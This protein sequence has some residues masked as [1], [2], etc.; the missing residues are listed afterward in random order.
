MSG[1]KRR[2]LTRRFDRGEI[3]PLLIPLIL[4]T[5]LLFGAAYFGYWA[6]MQRQD[7]KNNSDQKVAAAVSDAKKAEDIIKDQKFAEAEK[8]P[9]T[10]Y[11]GPS[12]FGSVHVDYP[13][14]WSVYVASPNGQPLNMYFN[15]KTVPPVTDYTSVFALRVQV[16]QQT[17]ANV[18]K[19]LSTYVT[20][21]VITMTPYSFP[22]VPSVVGVRV[23][24]QVNPGKKNIGSMIIVPM[25]DKTLEVWTESEQEIPD[26]NNIIL[27][28]FTFEP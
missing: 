2:T 19:N 17:Y 20:S 16:L 14:T 21:K 24:G 18:V 28:N 1:M 8:N 12:D 7:Y 10:P 4:V 6:Y 26:F 5:L 11:D 3:D 25:R 22:K 27:P 13:K 23:D 9:L 15:L